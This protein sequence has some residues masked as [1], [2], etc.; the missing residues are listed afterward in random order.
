MER[1][2]LSGINITYRK[3]DLTIYWYTQT[4]LCAVYVCSELAMA[5]LQK[6]QDLG[7]VNQRGVLEEI[8][9]KVSVH[10][11]FAGLHV[12]CNFIH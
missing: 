2:I 5:L 11:A 1:L 12:H 3:V 9:V 8:D 7:D 10:H 4:P 6:A